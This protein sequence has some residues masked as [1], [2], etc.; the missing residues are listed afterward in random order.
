ETL[1][2]HPHVHGVIA[3]GG[4]AAANSQ[5]MACGPGFFLPVKVLSRLFRDKFIAYLCKARD[6][7]QLAFAGQLS[8]LAEA[9]EFDRWARALRSMEWGVYAKPPFGGPR[10][11]LKYIASY[12]HPVPISNRRLPQPNDNR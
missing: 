2:S 1:E 11:V 3:G 8:H 10:Q 9:E 12:T 7:N 6:R 4:L 5:W